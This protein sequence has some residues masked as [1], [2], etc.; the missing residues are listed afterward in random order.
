[1]AAKERVLLIAR[2]IEIND[3]VCLNADGEIAVLGDPPKEKLTPIVVMNAKRV[4][5]VYDGD[6]VEITVGVNGVETHFLIPPETLVRVTQWK[7]V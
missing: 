5:D 6:V 3:T 1:M 2:C 4:N 7:D